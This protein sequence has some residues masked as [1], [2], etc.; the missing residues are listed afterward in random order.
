MR[1]PVNGKEHPKSYNGASTIFRKREG[2][3]KLRSSLYGSWWRATLFSRG[4]YSPPSIPREALC[5]LTSLIAFQFFKAKFS[6]P[7]KQ[8]F[9]TINLQSVILSIFFPIKCRTLFVSLIPDFNVH[10]KQPGGPLRKP[11]LLTGLL[12]PS[13]VI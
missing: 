7:L 10:M 5:Y 6:L 3:C 2:I 9:F 12:F 13:V 8:C 4:L 1:G 11:L